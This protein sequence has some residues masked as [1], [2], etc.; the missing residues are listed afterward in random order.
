VRSLLVVV[1]AGFL[2]ATSAAAKDGVTPERD[3]NEHLAPEAAPSDGSIYELVLHLSLF[4]RLKPELGVMMTRGVF[5]EMGVGVLNDR[6]EFF[7]IATKPKKVLVAQLQKAL[8]DRSSGVADQIAVLPTVDLKTT[9]SRTRLPVST[10]CDLERIW[11]AALSGV[12]APIER[13]IVMDGTR[14]HFFGGGR[15]GYTTSPD[16]GSPMIELTILVQALTEYAEAP[17]ASLP[18]AQEK[19]RSQITTAAKV[20]H[21]DIAPNHFT[22]Y[23]LRGGACLQLRDACYGVKPSPP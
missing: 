4:E 21:A 19:L 14:Y 3:A 22:D 15:A 18:A 16:P 11:Q 2:V 7:A 6:G 8:G 20:L 12:K 10:A 23:E 17:T 13:R 5:K 1:W 9:V